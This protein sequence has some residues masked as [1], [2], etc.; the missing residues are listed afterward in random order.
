MH[1]IISSAAGFDGWLALLPA[2]A[3][4]ICPACLRAAL[5]VAGI[6]GMNLW[7]ASWEN[8]KGVF[9]WVM[10]MTGVLALG[11]LLLILF[12]IRQRRL[13]FISSAL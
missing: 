2:H 4:K 9:I 7:N 10:I 6:F 1:H 8:S 5:Q 13:M 3:R 12:Y 11:M